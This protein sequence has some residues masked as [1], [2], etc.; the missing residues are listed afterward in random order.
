MVSRQGQTR[1]LW[2]SLEMALGYSQ[3]RVMLHET[4]WSSLEMA[5]GQGQTRV[6][7]QRV[8]TNITSDFLKTRFSLY[9]LFLRYAAHNIA[10]GKDGSNRNIALS[11]RNIA[12]SNRDIALINRNIALSNRNI[13]LSNHNI[14]LSN[15]NIA[16]SNRNILP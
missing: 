9:C 13:A 3:M 16:L 7:F 6:M 10:I 1:V 2:S 8:S 12:L 15:H 5:S 4:L 11:N 14:A